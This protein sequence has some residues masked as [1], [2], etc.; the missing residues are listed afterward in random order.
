MRFFFLLTLCLTAAVAAGAESLA[1]AI[2]EN[3]RQV[4]FVQTR[5][6]SGSTGMLRRWERK[7][8]HAPW[9]EVGAPVDALLGKHG[10]AWGI[11]LHPRTPR[12]GPVKTEGDLRAPA[13]VFS[14][15]Q[16]FGR[17]VHEEIP[18]LR[19][20]Y[21]RLTPTTEAVDDPASRFYN[22]IVDR[23]EVAQP[24]WH[25]SEKMW[26]IAAYELGLVIV[27]NAPRTPRAGSCIFLHL[28]MEG[29]QGTAGCTALHRPDLVELFR[30]LDPGKEAVL[31]QLPETAARESFPGFVQRRPERASNAGSRGLPEARP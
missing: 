24:D 8:S 19:W 14:L 21:R 30:W 5:G 13:G 22:R 18:W 9:S 16:A 3:C 10:L 25:S 17:A 26:E 12:D 31:V 7:D 28:W 2:P 20:P 11:G 1:T 4:V 6:W 15:G 27:H 23:A 29:S